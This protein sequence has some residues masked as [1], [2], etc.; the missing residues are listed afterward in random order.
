MS[1]IP[2][3]SIQLMVTSPPYFN[4]PFDYPDLFKDYDEFLELIRDLS[5]ELYRVLA[6]GRVACFVTDD[7]LVGGEK[8]PVVA[9][10]TRLMLDAGFRYRDR[11]VWVNPRATYE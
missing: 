8:Y 10:I 7:M 6:P 5:H 3:E 9:D 11:I 4:A 2:D 1:E